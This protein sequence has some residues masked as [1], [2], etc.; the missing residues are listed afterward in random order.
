MAEEPVIVVFGG[1]AGHPNWDIACTF[2]HE[3]LAVD[4]NVHNA[5]LGTDLSRHDQ[6]GRKIVLAA[7]EAL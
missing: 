7:A 6:A 2:E 1:H 3:G 4:L 5:P